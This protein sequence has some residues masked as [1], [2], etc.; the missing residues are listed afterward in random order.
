[1]LDAVLEMAA[2]LSLAV[3]VV[4]AAVKFGWPRLAPK[5]EVRRFRRKLKSVDGI[6]AGWADQVNGK[7]R[8]RHE[9]RHPETTDDL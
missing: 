1:M 5:M 4:L 2:Y 7:E 3:G 6:V 9:E 8:P